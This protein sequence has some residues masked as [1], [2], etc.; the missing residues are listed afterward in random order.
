MEVCHLRKGQVRWESF[1][2]PWASQ[3]LRDVSC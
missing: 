1:A 2:P 3:R